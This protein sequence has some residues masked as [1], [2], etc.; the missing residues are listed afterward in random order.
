MAKISRRGAAPGTG[1]NPAGEAAPL[2]SPEAGLGEPRRTTPQKLSP[3]PAVALV[4][5]ADLS[6]PPFGS[7]QTNGGAAPNLQAAQ[8]QQRARERSR[9]RQQK[10]AERIAAATEELASG[11]SQAAT[12]SDQL[13]KA[14]EQIA[15]GAE[16]AAGAAHQSQTAIS[17]I[18][19]AFVE[20]RSRAESARKKTEAL[21]AIV[22]EASTQIASAVAN[23]GASAERQA[24]SV[25]VVA[26]LEA[27]AANIEE[28]TRAVSQISDQTNLLALN[29]AIE[30]ARAGDHGR[31]F[32]V[33]ADEVRALAET[34]D[35]SAREI[36]ALTAKMQGEVKT[37]VAAINSAAGRALEEV[38]GGGGVSQN[39]EKIRLDMAALAEGSQAI[40]IASVE[41]E[42][43]AREAQKGSERI[44]SSA[45]QASAAAAEA[46][47]SIQQQASALGQS[48][49]TAHNLAT[50]ADDLRT[51]TTLSAT[52][53]EVGSAGEQLSATTQEL[54]IAAG[55]IMSAV[56]QIEKGAQ[57]QAGAT[58]E[59]SAA[60]VQIEK[61]AQ[62]ARD[63]AAAA[64]K[65]SAVSI[66][67][68]R[69]NRAAVE[70]LIGGVDQA[71][72]DTRASLGLIAALEQ[73]S[74]RIDKIVDG[75]SLVSV[76]TNML[77]VSGSVEAA[78]AGDFGRGFAVVSSDIRN[79]ARESG[80]N[81]G[82]IKDTVRTIQD[83]ISLVRRD[84]EQIIAAAD[85]EVQKSK[86]IIA[87]L[88]VMAADMAGVQEAGAGIGEGAEAILAAV[89]EATTSARQ[90]AAAAE[91][92][93]SAAAEAAAAAR[94]QARGAEDLAAATEEIASLADELQ[95]GAG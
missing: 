37:I 70:K 45:E 89:N 80:D 33:V 95:S 75:I 87:A 42:A 49:S 5:R 32:A 43:A 57:D 62:S 66:A 50:I 72:A 51:S 71:L 21:Q 4:K 74:R 7:A 60:M 63:A 52:A 19:T 1:R 38:K 11:V 79:L 9:A 36:Q 59:L 28:V 47:R 90:V 29:A 82:R 2:G 24:A 25:A 8:T 55:Q 84:L 58:Q 15:T 14:M 20:A 67:L 68:L 40:L 26:E 10:I 35:K 12:A 31:G 56:D 78:R 17:R 76:Q 65:S 94:Q 88:G 83:Q 13:R 18:A 54:S 81:A 46:L 16:E 77:A 23:V 34:S 64:S 86:S 91:E 61:S 41:A 48:Q 3:G 85:V 39:L 69:E 6:D 44:A 93:G 92:T 22:V 30:A 73:V 27:Q 53:E